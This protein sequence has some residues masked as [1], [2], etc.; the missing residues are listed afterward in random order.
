MSQSAYTPLQLPFTIFGLGQT[1]NFVD[2]IE[3]GIPNPPGTV[4]VLQ[5]RI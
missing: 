3:A 1:P 2:K 4:S 5:N